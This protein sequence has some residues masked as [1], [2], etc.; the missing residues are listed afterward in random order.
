MTWHAVAGKE[1]GSSSRV[2]PCPQAKMQ[3]LEDQVQGLQEK[4]KASVLTMHSLQH[5]SASLCRPFP[6]PRVRVLPNS[7]P[8][9]YETWDSTSV[10]AQT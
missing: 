3:A 7:R 10:P 4:L 8:N 2:R 9:T 1:S 5:A 6:W